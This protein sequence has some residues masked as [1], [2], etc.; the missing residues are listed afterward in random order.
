MMI[1]KNTE[2]KLTVI[3][4]DS[5]RQRTSHDLVESANFL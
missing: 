4:L 1:L 3:K 2:R 5:K